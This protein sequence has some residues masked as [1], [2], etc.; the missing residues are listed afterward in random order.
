MLQGQQIGMPLMITS[1][2]EHAAKFDGDT[3]I[4]ARTIEGDIS[5]QLCRGR[6]PHQAARQGVDATTH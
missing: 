4:V 5:L 6:P 1:L 2:I 3:A